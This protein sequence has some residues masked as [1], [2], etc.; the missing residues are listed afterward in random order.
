MIITKESHFWRGRIFY[1]LSSLIVG[2][3]LSLVVRGAVVERDVVLNELMWDGT[4]YIELFNR[5]PAD[6]SLDG[7]VITRQQ[8]DGDEK[9]IITFDDEATIKA[10]AYLL[11]E[12]NESATDIAADHIASAL[13]LVNGGELVT[14]KDDEGVVVDAANQLGEWFAGEN[15]SEGVAME[16]ADTFGDG[17]LAENWHTSV[18]V[19]GGRNGTP[20]AANSVPPVNQPPSGTITAPDVGFVGGEITFL[21][22]GLGDPDGDDVTVAWSFGDGNSASDPEVTHTYAEA[23]EFSVSLSISDGA[24]EI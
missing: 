1:L 20:G 5:T 8:A 22:A 15:T 6:I 14:L 19:V 13:T 17:T 9:I 11:I 4:E 16:R 10:D 21:A 12:K 24:I 18:G 23:G 3:G 2:F 7:W